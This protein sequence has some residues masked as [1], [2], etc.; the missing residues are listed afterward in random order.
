[1]AHRSRLAKELLRA[2]DRVSELPGIEGFHL[3]GAS[4]IT[5]H[6]GHR[7]SNDLELFSTTPRPPLRALQRASSKLPG[8]RVLEGTEGMVALEVDGVPVDLV[9]YPY[10]PLEPPTSGP[11]GFPTAGQLDLA[12]MKLAAI[13]R[14]GL[15]RDFWDLFEIVRAG[16]TLPAAGRAFV[17]RFSRTEGDLYHVERALTWFEDAERNPVPVDGLTTAKWEDIKLFFTCEGPQLLLS[18]R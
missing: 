6:L 11:H 16:V 5:W 15:K 7:R 9:K 4:A 2:L 3:A 14:R 8:F 18:G 10:P 13:A 1:M 17:A 12:A